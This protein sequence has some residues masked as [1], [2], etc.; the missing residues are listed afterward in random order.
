M[1]AYLVTLDRAKCGRSLSEGCDAMT[2]FAASGAAAKQIAASKYDGEGTAWITDGTATEIT[3]ASNWLGWTFK[4]QISGLP[5]WEV[6]YTAEGANDTI[7]EIGAALV[8]LF[9]ATVID[10]AAYNSTTQVL[11]VAG[12]A[13]NL[14]ASQLYVTITPPNGKSGIDSLVGTVVDGGIAGAVLSVVLPA[15]A[16]VIPSVPVSLTQV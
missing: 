4:F 2:V 3:A 7:D 6:S 5:S 14:G 10:A 16:A 11:T 15:D 12:V 1:P 9:N 8:V 13:D